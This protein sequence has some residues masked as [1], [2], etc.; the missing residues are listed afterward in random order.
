MAK[1]TKRVKKPWSPHKYL[2]A[3]ARKTW[4]WSPSRT[5]VLK[6]VKIGIDE[7]R[8]EECLKAVTQVD[9]ITKKGRKRKRID[10][11]VDHIKPVGKQPQSFEEWPA[12]LAK[13]YCPIEN[14]MFLCTTC[15]AI[16]SKAEAAARKK[17]K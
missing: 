11:A 6:R 5:E 14:L 2:V 16:K 7:W 13:M 17:K 10:G 1:K 3:A 15:H 8:C 4:Q 9:Y 12:Y